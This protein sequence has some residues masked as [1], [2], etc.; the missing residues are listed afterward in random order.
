MS[1][2]ENFDRIVVLSGG[3]FNRRNMLDLELSNAFDKDFRKIMHKRKNL[4]VSYTIYKTIKF[5]SGVISLGS[6]GLW[7]YEI[8]HEQ[9]ILPKWLVGILF[10]VSFMVFIISLLYEKKGNPIK[11]RVIQFNEITE[12]TQ[13]KQFAREI[14]RVIRTKHPKSSNAYWQPPH[15]QLSDGQIVQYLAEKSE[16]HVDFAYSG[17]PYYQ[18][19]FADSIIFSEIKPSI[20]ANGSEIKLNCKKILKSSVQEQNF[21]FFCGLHQPADKKDLYVYG[22]TMLNRFLYNLY[23]SYNKH[24][25]KIWSEGDKKIG[26]HIGQT[27]HDSVYKIT[28]YNKAQQDNK[29]AQEESK[30]RLKHFIN[31]RILHKAEKNIPKKDKVEKYYANAHKALLQL[32]H[33]AS[34]KHYVEIYDANNPSAPTLPYEE[35]FIHLD[36]VD[37]VPMLDPFRKEFCS[38]KDLMSFAR[39]MRKRY[40][41]HNYLRVP[42]KRPLVV[43]NSIDPKS[44]H[45][46]TAPSCL[47]HDCKE[48]TLFFIMGGAEQNYAIQAAIAAQSWKHNTSFHYRFIENKFR[49]YVSDFEV[50]TESL[51]HACYQSI[52]GTRTDISIDDDSADGK[53]IGKA[54]VYSFQ[55][56]VK[57]KDDASVSNTVITN[58]IGIYGYNA[59][60][61]KIVSM[62]IVCLLTTNQELIIK[63]YERKSTIASLIQLNRPFY[64]QISSNIEGKPNE[65]LPKQNED[66]LK[67]WDDD[68]CINNHDAF[69]KF[70]RQLKIEI[71]E[72]QK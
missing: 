36:V 57:Q 71:M 29:K 41:H 53:I 44:P 70:F 34:S 18:E 45:E 11:R 21:H 43:A 64:I 35:C 42:I 5:I 48:N 17:M 28:P 46:C 69:E 33:G 30:I 47:L 59:V 4:T 50:G 56:D 20:R 23:F 2:W 61:T 22:I 60:S 52:E 63:P 67:Q 15:G 62:S 49:P 51:V 72:S 55:M 10:G 13:I 54:H 14:F 58:C 40:Q 9:I 27:F 7:V 66:L 37:L 3:N 68:D 8:L 1:Y 19:Y 39:L 38:A 31:Q 16:K 25:K 24:D 65:D 12:S 26:I 6:L 32:L